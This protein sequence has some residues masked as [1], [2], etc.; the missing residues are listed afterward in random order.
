MPRENIE[1][2][3][4]DSPDSPIAVTDTSVTAEE[5]FIIRLGTSLAVGRTVKAFIP[6]TAPLRNDFVGIYYSRYY[7]DGQLK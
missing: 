5:F 7:L 2:Y 6:Y 1:V 3:Y 4:E